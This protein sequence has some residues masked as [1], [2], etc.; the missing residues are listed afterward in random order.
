MAT[1]GGWTGLFRKG[2]AAA[3]EASRN[4]D[5]RLI[6]AIG[7]VHGRYDLLKALLAQLATDWTARAKGRRPALIFCGDYI[8]RG[9]QSAEVIEALIWL[10]RNAELEVRTLKGNHEQAFL[11]FVN[12]PE[13]GRDWMRFGGV[14]TLKSYGVTAPAPEDEDARFLRAR[15]DLLQRMP[16]SHLH[17]LSTLELMVVCGDYAFVHAGIRPGTPLDR[18]QEEDLLWIRD[19]F[20]EWGGSHGGKTIVHG[21]TWLDEQPQVRRH[22]IGIDTGAY[23]T[24]VLTALRLDRDGAAFIQAHST[25]RAPSADDHYGRRPVGVAAAV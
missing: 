3:D 15:D 19:E 17:L 22:R 21:H 9:P 11:E 2:D 4:V 13:S 25:E 1:M 5:G 12:A 6:Y 7:D 10:R 20:M 8:D 16:A 24:G 23:A 18:Q 14:E